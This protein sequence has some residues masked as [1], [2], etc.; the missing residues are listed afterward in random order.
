MKRWVSRGAFPLMMVACVSW[1]TTAC[2]RDGGME[3]TYS[4]GFHTL[5]LR[6]GGEAVF[7]SAPCTY[8][9]DEAEVTVECAGGG[10]V[11]TRNDDGSLVFPAWELSGLELFERQE[12][13]DGTVESGNIEEGPRDAVD[14]GDI[15]AGVEIP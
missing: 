14:E 5:E 10:A 1:I 4:N 3:G 7:M 13:G 8:D 9:V 11:F 2:S 15:E 6:R 12:D